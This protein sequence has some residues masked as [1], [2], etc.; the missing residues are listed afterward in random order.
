MDLRPYWELLRP[1]LAPMDLALPAASALL[2]AFATA[3]GL[4]PL[5]PFLLATFGAYCAITSS[6]VFNDFVDVDVDRVGM[7]DRPLPSAR[8]SRSTAGLYAL[9][10][11][12]I[13]GAVALYLN[14]ESFVMLAVSTALITLYSRWAKRSTPFSWVLVGLAFGM[15]PVGVWLAM[16]PAGILKAGPGLHP[17]AVILGAMICITDWGF[18]NCDASRDFAGDRKKGIP[19]TPATF[20]VPFTARMVAV[21]W[22]IGVVLSLAL[23]LAAGLGILY[24]GVAVFAGSWI[25]AQSID[26]VR[27]P[28]PARGDALFYQSANYRAALFLALIAD[29]LLSALILRAGLL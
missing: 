27:K 11:F 28:T 18:T 29:V 21:F 17:A 12:G 26:F 19:T 7:P 3:G 14:P 8:I 5:V 24:Q 4:P 10:L 16:A 2:A 1:P 13:A 25:L 6:Y 9:F 22:G 20:G 23:G 15:V